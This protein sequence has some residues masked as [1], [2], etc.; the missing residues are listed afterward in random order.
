M[1]REKL[2]YLMMNENIYNNLNKSSY[3]ESQKWKKD[4]IVEKWIEVI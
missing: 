4:K 2:E 3:K 1:F